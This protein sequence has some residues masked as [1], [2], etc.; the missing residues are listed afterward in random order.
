MHSLATFDHVDSSLAPAAAA[1]AFAFAVALAWPFA[2]E[3]AV[4]WLAFAS[5]GL[6]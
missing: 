6:R 2:L 4:D 5:F 1:I 3:I